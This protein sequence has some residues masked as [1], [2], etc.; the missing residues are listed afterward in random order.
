MG[1]GPFVEA[2]WGPLWIYNWR[3][4]L[5]PLAQIPPVTKSSTTMAKTRKSRPTCLNDRL[6]RGKRLCFAVR[7]GLCWLCHS[8]NRTFQSPSTYLS[9][10]TSFTP[11]L[12]TMPSAPRS[13]VKYP[14]QGQMLSGPFFISPGAAVRLCT[15]TVNCVDKHLCWKR[16]QHLPMEP[17]R[18]FRKQLGKCPFSY[19]TAVSSLPGSYVPF[20]HTRFLFVSG[21]VCLFIFCLIIPGL[22]CLCWPG[23]QSES[24]CLLS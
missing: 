5:P 20:S 2:R 15:I 23:I 3:Q 8:Q 7:L 6:G 24:N 9:D 22:K 10:H 14:Y 18:I 4:W 12:D 13:L 17:K 1:L 19:T 16:E 11:S 21:F